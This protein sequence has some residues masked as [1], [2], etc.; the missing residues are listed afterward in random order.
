[1]R[2]NRNRRGPPSATLLADD[3]SHRSLR[4][5]PG[6]TAGDRAGRSRGST[7]HA[8]G[9]QTVEDR[10]GVERNDSGDGRPP[11]GDDDVVAV[12]RSVDPLTEVGSEF[13]HGNIHEAKC[14][15]ELNTKRTDLRATRTDR[16][17]RRSSLHAHDRHLV[18]S[19][20]ERC[21]PRDRCGMDGGRRAGSRARCYRREVER[22]RPGSDGLAGPHI[23]RCSGFFGVLE[24]SR[25]AGDRSP[26]RWPF[27][28]PVAA[29]SSARAGT[30]SPRSPPRTSRV[31]R[32]QLLMM[33]FP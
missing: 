7:D 10:S 25:D 18:L 12:T 17:R 16:H 3:V 2:S 14:T 20:C 26:V 33:T 13:R 4:L 30:P 6:P 23:E 8:F 5:R 21:C 28:C 11:I 27:R 15:S 29:D 1:M 32:C 31:L 19:G 9:G 22:S 24:R